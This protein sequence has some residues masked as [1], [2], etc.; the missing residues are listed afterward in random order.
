[1]G[2]PSTTRKEKSP[3]C[4]TKQ[5][6]LG[7]CQRQRRRRRG[8]EEWKINVDRT[9]NPKQ[10]PKS[11]VG[12]SYKQAWCPREQYLRLPFCAAQSRRLEFHHRCRRTSLTRFLAGRSE[13]L[14]HRSPSSAL[15][16]I[17]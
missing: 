1:M 7:W 14:A 10:L 4:W 9:S 12:P 2:S 11:N 6:V 3:R 16:D 8:D 13:K 17:I 15:A 5:M